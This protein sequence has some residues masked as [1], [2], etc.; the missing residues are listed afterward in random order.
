MKPFDLTAM[1][2]LEP[3]FIYK[4]LLGPVLGLYSVNVIPQICRFMY[5]PSM[6]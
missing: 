6:A 1:T 5:N 4:V 3:T 2:W